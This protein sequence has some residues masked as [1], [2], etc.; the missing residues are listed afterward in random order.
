MSVQEY[1]IQKLRGIVYNCLDNEQLDSAQLNVEILCAQNPANLDSI[2][3]HGL[4]LYRRGLYK[5]AY[6]LTANRMHMGCAYV[7]ALCAL[8][9]EHPQE[10]IYV[11]QRILDTI[12]EEGISEES[13]ESNLGKNENQRSV[14]P[15]IPSFYNLL[16]K[17][18]ASMDDDVNTVVCYSKALELNPFLFEA[19]EQLS[20]LG[21]KV[22]IGNVY[23]P[24]STFSVNPPAGNELFERMA[25]DTSVELKQPEDSKPKGRSLFGRSNIMGTPEFS[26]NKVKN[27][28]TP[29]V[30]ELKLPE[31]PTRKTRSS[32]TSDAFKPPPA[33]TTGSFPRRSNRLSAS[34]VT[35]RLLMQPISGLG[36]PS[37]YDNDNTTHMDSIKAN[38]DSWLKRSY[39]FSNM[40]PA[41]S[42]NSD[43]RNFNEVTSE[44]ELIVLYGRIARA[45]KAFC[46]YDCF[47]AIRL[48]TSLP[49]HV[50]D[51]PWVLAKLG[52]LHFEI[53][54]YEQSEFY[55]QKLRQIDRTRTEDMEYYSTLL[56]HLHKESE[57]SYLSHEL[58]QIDKFAP[59][60]WVA[61]GNL[62]SLNRD[63]EEAVK[64]FHKATQLDQNFAYAYT[65]QG[66]EHVANDSFENA[67]ES[68]RY[69]LSI[70][71]RHYNALY[72]L[73]M[74]HLKLGDFTKA[75]F[76]FRKAIDINPV[77]VILTC[78]VGMVLE[79]LGK[80]ELSLKQYDFA[81]KLQ[82]LS[83]LALF[84][85]AQ[86][87]LALQQY[88][89]AL[90]DFE[91]L[92]KLAPDEASV[93]FLLGELYKQLGRKSDAIKQLT[94]ALNLDP[95]GSHVVK[96]S[97]EGIQTIDTIDEEMNDH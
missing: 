79:K 52:R 33:N 41:P 12:R 27:L 61:I 47:K 70:D 14:L 66:H 9:L 82:P 26:K 50:V 13:M 28:T 81:C 58:Y 25:P 36:T 53:V 42:N 59:Q 89:L 38:K 49:E 51:M 10:G 19:F 31:A 86:V 18:Y 75:E 71:K 3:L 93:H 60:T 11:L 1:N 34:K 48:F 22:K 87:L 72:G 37:T 80:R 45:Y 46:Q 96:E 16:G 15:D 35:S 68:F 84:K 55:F 7:F 74:V 92:Q 69:A 67:F 54:N 30:R 8:K 56:W 91:K 90:K 77:N 63:N 73:G 39:N 57:L 83:M 29:K 21:A 17:L 78:C 64:C 4:V 40:P 88:D 95:K 6:N 23:K 24:T 32:V 44:N 97:L 62:F 65:L 20:K 43:F 2:H 85:K 94:I 5:S 76:H